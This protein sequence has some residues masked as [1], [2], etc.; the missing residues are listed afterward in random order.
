MDFSEKVKIEFQVLLLKAAEGNISVQEAEQLNAIISACPE[1][2]DYYI[3][4]TKLMSAIRGVEDNSNIS[5]EVYTRMARFMVNLAKEEEFAPPVEIEIKN[6]PVDQPLH[7]QINKDDLSPFKIGVAIASI[8]AMLIMVISI[9]SIEKVPEVATLAD[10]MNVDGSFC[11]G[12][13]V[14]ADGHVQELA[15]GGLIKLAYDNQV[16]AIVEGPAVFSVLSDNSLELVSGNVFV[17]VQGVVKG[18]TVV[19]GN[20]KIVDLGTQFGVGVNDGKTEVHVM[21]GKTVVDD[22]SAYGNRMLLTAGLA[23]NVST[24]GQI[25]KT[26]FNE[27]KFVRRFD[28]QNDFIWNGKSS[29]SL[30]DLICGGDGFGSNNST[31]EINP[32][33]G[34]LKYNTNP[35]WGNGSSAE[36]KYATVNNSIV[37]GVFVPGAQQSKEQVIS[38]SGLKTAM[39][40]TSGEYAFFLTN[41]NTA[42]DEQ[43]QKDYS[44]SLGDGYGTDSMLIMHSNL[45]MTIALKK[46]YEKYPEL[47]VT[48]FECVCGL[49]AILNTVVDSVSQTDQDRADQALVDVCILID[50]DTVYQ[51]EGIGLAGE[52]QISISLPAGAEFMTIMVTDSTGIINYDWAEFVNPVFR[53]E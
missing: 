38:S 20:S 22:K 33:S 36:A 49:P 31:W 7:R 2:V 37:D 35:V 16:E 15:D 41:K 3:K 24:E 18:F 12:Q 32:V 4:H 26:S 13:R 50:G 27:E 51:K 52:Q 9:I 46:V 53:I 48:S 5:D 42:Y 1:S 14:L 39:P 44:L 19:T 8:A 10:V 17:K 45:G 29:V 43:T 40:E 25:N 28:S 6:E 11:C 47:K 23:C 34:E 21:K 30:I